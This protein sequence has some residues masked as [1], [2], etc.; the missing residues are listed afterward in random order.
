MSDNKSF[1]EDMNTKQDKGFQD[2]YNYNEPNKEERKFP[3][4]F[5]ILAGILGLLLAILISQ[6]L[7]SSKD[8]ADVASIEVV[9]PIT[10]IAEPVEDPDALAVANVYSEVKSSGDKTLD[11]TPSTPVQ[12][13][14]VKAPVQEKEVKVIAPVKTIKI[15]KEQPVSTT[16]AATTGW[17]VQLSASAT[18]AAASSQWTKL[19]GQNS[20]LLGN[21]THSIIKKTVSGKTVY[22]LRVVGLSSS[23]DADT[24]CKSLKARNVACFVT[25]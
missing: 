19:K 9:A 6:M 3:V 15:A 10:E 13:V 12:K 5:L 17:Q 18:E 8:D 21:K 23:D 11:T 25:R 7:S 2:Y 20:D 1:F 14:E 24:L 16:N 4:L 22:R